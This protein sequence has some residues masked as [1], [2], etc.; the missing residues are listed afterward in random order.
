MSAFVLAILTGCSVA[1]YNARAEVQT[2][3]AG[4]GPNEFYVAANMYCGPMLFPRAN[5]DKWRVVTVRVL[6][7][8]SSV[9]PGKKKPVTNCFTAAD[10]DDLDL[11]ITDANSD[12]F[13]VQ[14]RDVLCGYW[15]FLPADVEWGFTPTDP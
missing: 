3:A 14:G 2:I 12:R 4:G 8:E 11:A 1:Y 9:P 13:K 10:T 5:P 15:Y 7:C 6:H